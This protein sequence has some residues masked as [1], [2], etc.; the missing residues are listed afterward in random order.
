MS[1]DLRNDP[2]WHLSGAYS[3]PTKRVDPHANVF[4]TLAS[5]EGSSSSPP[6]MIVLT[7][8]EQNKGWALRKFTDD[9]NVNFTILYQAMQDGT[10]K[11]G[12]QG[13]YMCHLPASFV[14][15]R[16]LAHVIDQHV[17]YMD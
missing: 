16:G 17:G 6:G 10:F 2:N 13:A 12:T 3:P 8:F 5:Y 4:Q 9:N 7:E 14:D 1:G 11:N 15:L